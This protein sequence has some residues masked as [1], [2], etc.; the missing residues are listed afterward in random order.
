MHLYIGLGKVL[1]DNLISQTDM[2]LNMQ[3][4]GRCSI[5]SDINAIF[6]N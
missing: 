1:N 5:Y 4:H 3:W 6:D 2:N